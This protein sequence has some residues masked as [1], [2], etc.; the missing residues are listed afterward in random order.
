[1][2]AQEILYKFYETIDQVRELER[3]EVLDALVPMVNI[4]RQY[5]SHTVFGLEHVPTSGPALL[6]CN[7]SL[8][9]YDIACLMGAIYNEQKR[10]PRGL[11]DRAFFK[12]PGL[13]QLM[14]FLGSVQGNQENAQK[15]LAAGELITVAPGGM[16]E[17]LKPSSQR[18][19]I[20]WKR[21][22]GFARLAMQTGTPIVLAACPKADDIYE[23]YPNKLTAWAYRTYKIPIFLARGVGPTP[24]P[25]PVT[26]THFLS[27]AITPPPIPKSPTAFDDV[28]NAFHNE[29]YER[30]LELINRGIHYDGK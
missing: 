2:N 29:L 11:I 30:M 12:F 7:H 25:K 14:E 5:H 24:I 3:E 15:L 26:L 10:I 16:R 23:V 28:L 6:V 20:K 22:R 8:A 18:Y 4:L 19:Q 21:R 27:E 17:A 1:M 9:T 13:G